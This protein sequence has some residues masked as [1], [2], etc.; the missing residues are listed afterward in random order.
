MSTDIIALDTTNLPAHLQSLGGGDDDE[1]SS[2][3]TAGF[4]IISTKGKQFTIRRGEDMELLMNPKD[5]DS[6]ASYIDVVVLKTHPGVCKTYYQRTYEEGSDDKPDCYS[7]NGIEPA[8]DAENRQSKVC[9][10]C[11]QNQWG[12]RITD[13]GKEAKQCSDVKR[14]AVSAGGQINDPMLLR[15]PPTSLRAW[16]QYV[17]MLKKRGLKP[18]Q[19][20]TR[21]TF[22]PNVAHQL[23]V[24]KTSDFITPEM[25]PDI[26]AEL[27]GSTLDAIIGSVA[28]T[29]QPVGE[30][31]PPAPTKPKR[32][33][34]A[35][36]ATKVEEP[37]DDEENEEEPP[38]PP[39]PKAKRKRKPEPEPEQD[40]SEEEVEESDEEGDDD[41][42]G[43]DDLDFGDLDFGDD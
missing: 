38:A 34:P 35:K 24:F 21:I 32:K 15:V 36:K 18:T 7:L 11:P 28:T 2:G 3:T 5:P 40:T 4:P 42:D 19:C 27:R 43:L 12:S 14:L 26:E 33:P 23:L 30:D 9:A 6:P 37:T 41:L 22:D 17:D 16:D 39:K 20:I 13:S 31:K 10:T 25:V 29:S 8:A 1:W